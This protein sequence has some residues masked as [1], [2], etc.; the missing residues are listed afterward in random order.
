ML[1]IITLIESKKK[2]KRKGRKTVSKKGLNS[3]FSDLSFGLKVCVSLVIF[4]FLPGLIS[5]IISM[6]KDPATPELMSTLGSYIKERTLGNLSAR[7]YD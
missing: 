7:K 4:C 2:H 3:T 6:T 5:F 1:N